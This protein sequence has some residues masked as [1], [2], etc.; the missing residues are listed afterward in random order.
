MY[1]NN[2]DYYAGDQIRIFSEYCD[3][4]LLDIKLNNDEINNINSKKP[5]WHLGN[6]NFNY[7]RNKITYKNSEQLDA[8]KASLMY[9]NYFIVTLIFKDNRLTQIESIDFNTKTI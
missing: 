9:G 2:I 3:T 1:K 8:D 4:E 6:W 7:I 5:Y